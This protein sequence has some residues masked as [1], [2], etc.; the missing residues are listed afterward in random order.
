MSAAAVVTLVGV[1]ILVLALASY[2]ITIAW[3]LRRSVD[4]LGLVTFGV[5]AIAHRVQPLEELVGQIEDDLATVD[6]ALGDL[7]YP[8]R[9]LTG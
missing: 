7:L 4:T 6:D 1:A 3:Y 5:R 8:D 2:L 9:R